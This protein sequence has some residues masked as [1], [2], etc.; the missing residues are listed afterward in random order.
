MIPA[1]IKAL[2]QFVDFLHSNI[3]NFNQYN[4]LINELQLLGDERQ[5]V[6]SKRNFTDKLKY[7][8]VQN[9]IEQ[10]FKI[11]KENTYIPI[12]T[13]AIEFNVCNF[14]K[15]P[16]Y[17]WNGV[18]TDIR[19]LKENFSTEDLSEIFKHKNQYIEYRTKTHKTFLSMQFFF[20]ELDELLKELFDFF[21]E[22]E[23]NE[24]EAFETK[25]VK[26]NS[27]HEAVELLR[28]GKMNIQQRMFYYRTTKWNIPFREL[29]HT[30]ETVCDFVKPICPNIDPLRYIEFFLDEIDFDSIEMNPD[31]QETLKYCNSI[32]Y[33]L[34]TLLKADVSNS[35]SE[36][37]RN[38]STLSKEE[39]RVTQKQLI[40][41][42]GNLKRQ[43]RNFKS[44]ASF[45]QRYL[46]FCNSREQNKWLIAIDYQLLIADFN[47]TI[48][49]DLIS[50]F[51]IINETFNLIVAVVEDVP[52]QTINAEID[53]AKY[54]AKHH[55][56]TY[57]IECNTNGETLPRGNKKELERIGN[58][59]M[60]SGKGNRF[61]KVFNE[62]I[63]TDINVENNLIEIAGENWRTAVLK[64]SQVPHLVEQYLQSKQ[65]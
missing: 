3:G 12:R 32:Y 59:R 13:K 50:S 23:Q 27:V 6:S 5:K 55:V 51:E 58:E 46:A 31:K 42:I 22:T 2:F 34:E 38:I 17:G 24:F 8:E 41:L 52:T 16:S 57:L 7:D 36:Y 25:I 65:L 9:E 35:I 45:A 20:D 54:T 60:G 48:V 33:G 56:L 14:E 47:E 63:N 40:A 64:L 21:K 4:E 19:Q 44:D 28:T 18:E 43:A 37:Q 26:V 62:I 30:V 29:C 1:K 15:E 49:N 10:K 53:T 39:I 11:L 61:Y